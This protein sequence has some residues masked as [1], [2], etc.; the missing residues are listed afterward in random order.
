MIYNLTTVTRQVN[1]IGLNRDV[2][3]K[4]IFVMRESTRLHPTNLIP[5]GQDWSRLFVRLTRIRGYTNYPTRPDPTRPIPNRVGSGGR[6]IERQTV[7]RGDGGSI[8]PTAVSK[9][10]Q[11]RSPHICLCLSEET[12]KA[13]GPVVTLILSGVYARG[14]KRSHTGKQKIPHRG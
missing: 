8:P 14:S 1:R 11:F 2:G 13:D 7:N 12:L 3:L 5:T 10:R 4:C 6:A 9:L